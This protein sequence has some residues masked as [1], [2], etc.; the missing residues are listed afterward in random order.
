MIHCMRYM[1]WPTQ[2][3]DTY[4]SAI[5][6][7]K[8]EEVQAVLTG[9]ITWIHDTLHGIHELAHTTQDNKKNCDCIIERRRGTSCVDSR[10]STLRTQSASPHL[11]TIARVVSSSLEWISSICT[12]WLVSSVVSASLESWYRLVRLCPDNQRY[13]TRF[14]L[15]KRF[16]QESEKQKRYLQT[17]GVWFDHW[18]RIEK[19]GKYWT[20]L[21][22]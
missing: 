20:H 13:W 8:E 11:Y 2:R 3:Q 17:T 21:L 9:Y 18:Q 10:Q 4:V 22:V 1:N 5:V 16:L 15:S 14:A 19:V 6:S 12:S 7:Q